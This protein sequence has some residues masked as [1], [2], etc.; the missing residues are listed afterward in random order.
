MVSY[1]LLGSN[2]MKVM[3]ENDSI[4]LLIVKKEGENLDIIEG[5]KRM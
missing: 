4:P 1:S 2:T 3:K 5:L